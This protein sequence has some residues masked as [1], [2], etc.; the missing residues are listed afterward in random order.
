MLALVTGASSG[1]G[2]DIAREL[3]K[4]K[5]DVIIVARNE[6]ALQELKEELEKQYEVK[7][8]VK[9][10]DLSNKENCIKLYE[11]VKAE[12]ENIDVLINNA[13]LGTCGRFTDTSL[14]KEQ[15]IIDTNI[16]A[17]HILMKLFLK[18]MCKEGKGYIM[19]VASIAGFMPGPL[20]ATYYASK[21]YVVR[22]TQAVQKELKFQK[23]N[24]KVSVLCPGPVKTNFQKVADVKFNSPEA[25]S[26]VVARKAVEKMFKGRKIIFSSW[27]ISLVRFFAKILPD[28]FMAFCCYFVQRR[29]IQ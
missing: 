26:S 24:V 11:E 4:R 13:G 8:Y 27:Y 1:I 19:N 10:V 29:K 2:R 28:S 18:D 20:M 5:D 21:A 3:A 7:A 6:K 12:F 25:E 16:T 22:L 15:Q 9:I 14:E 17:L 23:S